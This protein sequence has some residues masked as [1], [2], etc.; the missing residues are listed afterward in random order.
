MEDLF[1]DCYNLVSVNISSFDI[2]NT[3]NMKGI[4]F[5]GINLKYLDLQNFKLSSAN[6]LDYIFGACHSMIYLN[7]KNFKIEQELDITDPFLSVT[8][9]I[10]YCIIDEY[11]KTKIIGEKQSDCS[12]ICFHTNIKI[13]EG[14]NACVESCGKN[15]FEFFN[16]CFGDCPDNTYKILLDRKTCTYEVPENFYL[17]DDNIY[18]ECY[19]TCKTCLTSGDE[20][21]N[22][23]DS[24][25][26]DYTF[27]NDTFTN[28]KNCF[29]K[30]EFYYYFDGEGQ[31]HCTSNKA[32][33]E[34]YN[35]LINPL[36][37][38]ID[39]C[40]K[41]RYYIYEDNNMCLE[42]CP[43]GK[44]YNN[45][46]NICEEK[47]NELIMNSAVLIK[48]IITTISQEVSEEDR[49]FLSFQE[50]LMTGKLNALIKNITDNK[51]DYIQ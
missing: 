34:I 29:K 43:K 33:P 42:K 24:C 15:T 25:I 6:N 41:D 18:K 26:D 31:Y 8:K 20:N 1:A 4:F 30:C 44:I 17:A 48:D 9:E 10:K 2:S 14:N 51:E 13:N 37:K 3:I 12:D 21:N 36:N 27:I 16:I 47:K 39:S 45:I 28:N 46:T 38:C 5:N 35:K 23:C 22:N 50:Q 32:C 19:Q 49:F 7:L 40:R 11:T